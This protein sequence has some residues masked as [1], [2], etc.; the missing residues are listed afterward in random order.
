MRQ[1]RQSRANMR[2]IADRDARL[3]CLE[4]LG[5]L[6]PKEVLRG[7]T[8]EEGVDSFLVYLSFTLN[9]NNFLLARERASLVTR[10]SCSMALS[11]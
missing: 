11:S 5:S 4:D 9:N 8:S 6:L 3:A 1:T 10:A 7:P 2:V